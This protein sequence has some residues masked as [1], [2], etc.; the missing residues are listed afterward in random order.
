MSNTRRR[1]PTY[2]G[3]VWE[4]SST[5]WLRWVEVDGT[6]RV[7]FITLRPLQPTDRLAEGVVAPTGH[8]VW[9]LAGL[10]VEQR[11]RGQGHG[12][13]L[14]ERGGAH[15]LDQTGGDVWF[16]LMTD[17]LETPLGRTSW[18]IRGAWDSFV[19]AH[20]DATT[21]GGFILLTSGLGLGA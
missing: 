8:E 19:A 1:T 20:S 9:L 16:G 17:N 13:A 14:L 7:G 12:R 2:T 6:D 21:S 4:T 18:S 11:Y 3:G 5:G 15:L 10:L